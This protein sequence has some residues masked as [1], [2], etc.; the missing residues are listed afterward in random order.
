[1]TGA[2]QPLAVAPE[3]GH[4]LGARIKWP[5]L[6]GMAIARGRRRHIYCVGLPKTGTHSI[7]NLFSSNYAAAHE[8]RYL[9]LI[10]P[11]QAKCWG[12]ADPA[13]LRAVLRLR[14]Y[15]LWLDLESCH[16]LGQ[17]VPE[18]VET[19]ADARFILPVRE[20]WAWLDSMIDDQFLHLDDP[21]YQPWWAVYDCYFGPRGQDFPEQESALQQA[22]LYPLRSYLRYY[23]QTQR[24]I[25]QAV[26]AE[27]LLVLPTRAIGER[28]PALA[29]FSGV[30]LAQLNAQ[31]SHSYRRSRHS[32][33]LAGI[34]KAYVAQVMAEE[35]RDWPLTLGRMAGETWSMVAGER[36]APTDD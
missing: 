27:R 28:L 29:R 1:M 3:L 7:A 12:R 35:L 19:F 16:V 15:R 20:P 14:R 13:A 21:G 23:A 22:G 26:P 25:I 34:D 10:R 11:L 17:F 6:K 36:A 4:A 5:L 32:G 30:P 24:N 18:L 31:G 9:R 8:P 2:E 33:L